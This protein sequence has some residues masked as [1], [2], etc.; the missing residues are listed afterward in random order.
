MLQ[1]FRLPLEKRRV[2]Q[3]KASLK[4]RHPNLPCAFASDK[5][6]FIILSVNPPTTLAVPLQGLACDVAAATSKSKPP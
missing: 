4:A 3:H 6:H 2:R 5:D 1:P